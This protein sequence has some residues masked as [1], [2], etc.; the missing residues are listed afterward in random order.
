MRRGCIALAVFGGL[1][2]A[3]ES[4]AHATSCIGD[5]WHV[6]SFGGEAVPV[7][8]RP[9]MH[10]SCPEGS[11]EAQFGSCT[12]V[13]AALTVAVT[14]ES[15]GTCE[16]LQESVYGYN[17]ERVVYFVPAEP[18]L[19]GRTYHLECTG[20]PDAEWSFT[21]RAST[22][23]AAAPEAVS[24]EI[25]RKQ[26]DPD[27]CCGGSDYLV[28]EGVDHTARYL[29]EGGLIEVSYPTGEVVPI[30]GGT[31]KSAADLQLSVEIPPSS[32]P[33]E[34]TPIAADGTRG[35]ATRIERRDIFVEPLYIPCAVSKGSNALA[36][37]LLGPLLWIGARGRRRRAR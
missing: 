13:S 27:G 24:A 4:S 37:W 18:L 15:S 16:P 17:P 7:D 29:V 35:A 1:L 25:R 34:L 26:G 21:T 8:F 23:P 5:P 22:E 19:P 12:L 32:G 33:L 14:L 2:A 36:L 30:S 6:W 20:Q 10:M 3:L 9:W 31:L 28:V 11:T